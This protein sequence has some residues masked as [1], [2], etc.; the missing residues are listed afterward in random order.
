MPERP[1]FSVDPAQI[2]EHGL[3]FDLTASAA[4][5]DFGEAGFDLGG[6]LRLS[7]RI[8]RVQ[9][10]GFRLVGELEGDVGLECVRCLEP[11]RFA[12]A[13]PLDLVFLPGGADS[14]YHPAASG[15]AR[16]RSGGEQGLGEDE[17]NVSFF[18]GDRL[19][20]A[21]T[22]WEQSHLALP[23]QPLCASACRGLCPGCGENRNLDS[24]CRCDAAD[25]GGG[26]FGGLRELLGSR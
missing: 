2:P 15:S 1:R 8:G 23:F 5:L 25:S 7:G 20:L 22:V 24:R 16:S 21:E 3:S 10:G 18:T 6:P 19:L 9:G 4:D 13:E 14:G 17:M 12:I 26:A 11:F